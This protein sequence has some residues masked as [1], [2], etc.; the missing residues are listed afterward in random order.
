MFEWEKWKPA[1]SQIINAVIGGLIV[2]VAAPWVAITIKDILTPALP[3]GA[4]VLVNS[5]ECPVGSGWQ[6]LEQASSRFLVAVGNGDENQQ[7]SR[8]KNGPGDEGSEKFALDESHLPAHSHAI[9]KIY[10]VITELKYGDGG[11]GTNY[12]QPIPSGSITDS[13]TGNIAT[14]QFAKSQKIDVSVEEIDNR[15]PHYALSV[16]VRT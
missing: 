2:A 1:P 13:S 7:L 10:S 6:K 14:P 12:L 9:A 5:N 3:P 15:P 4:V 11:D 16:C 8:Y